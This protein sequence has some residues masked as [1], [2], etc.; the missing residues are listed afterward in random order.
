[1]AQTNNFDYPK[2]YA[3]CLGIDEFGDNNNLVN[4]VRDAKIWSQKFLNTF[5]YDEIITL[6]NQDATITNFIASILRFAAKA[7]PGDI[8]TITLA[9]HGSFK[10]KTNYFSLATGLE[11]SED[12]IYFLLK[13][14][15]PK[16][17][18]CIFSDLC[19]GGTF[20]EPNNTREVQG[21]EMKWILD[22]LKGFSPADLN[23]IK[24]MFDKQC[25]IP[26]TAS[27]AHLSPTSDDATILDGINLSLINKELVG[28][29]NTLDWYTIVELRDKLNEL[30]ISYHRSDKFD[31]A[32]SFQNY[33]NDCPN[34]K[35]L[36]DELMNLA[37]VN[38]IKALF[39]KLGDDKN[40]KLISEFSKGVILN[41]GILTTPAGKNDIEE[42]KNLFNIFNG[43]LSW[44]KLIKNNTPI[45]NF[46]GLRSQAFR[47]QYIFAKYS[48]AYRS[49]QRG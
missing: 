8:V 42:K 33:V 49:E 46:A 22:S 2:G 10:G 35:K 12:C 20:V 6:T 37:G 13:A 41:L 19:H 25:E 21:R 44:K 7:L 31:Y 28:W 3:I 4:A 9:T 23:T 34:F 29:R 32:S 39:I 14:F 15:R 26:I 30:Y 36:F 1:M 38:T 48:P 16:V 11:M 43:Y 47:N 40:E 45:I 18:I 5:K 24:E 17:R 27:V